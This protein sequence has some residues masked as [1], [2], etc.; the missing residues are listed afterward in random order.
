MAS[1]AQIKA[2][3]NNSLRSTG[4]KTAKGKFR[5]RGNALKHGQR[6]LTLI[7]GLTHEDPQLLRGRPC[8]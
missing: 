4:P 2:N 1:A 7:P 8:S 5:A 3:H 6:A